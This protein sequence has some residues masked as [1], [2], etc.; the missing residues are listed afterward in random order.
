MALQSVY[1]RFLTAPDAS[2]LAPNASLY[3]ITTLVTING[4]TEIIK[5][6]KNQAY[7]LSKKEQKVLSVVG[8]DNSL[9]LE[10]H[11]TIEFGTGGGS[12]LPGLD[13]NFLTDRIVTL[14]MV[15]GT[16]ASLNHC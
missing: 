16:D 4:P 8:G 7:H 11:T 9:A 3:Y 2:L 14:P 15:R 12:Y 5:H 1:Q 6:L 10:V 13:D